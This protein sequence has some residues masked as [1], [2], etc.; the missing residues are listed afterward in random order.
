MIRESISLGIA[1][2][3]GSLHN[4]HVRLHP[5]HLPDALF[6]PGSSFK[7]G[8][9]I[10]G[11]RRNQIGECDVIFAN[12]MDFRD[13]TEPYGKLPSNLVTPGGSE[14][15]CTAICLTPGVATS[16][17]P[18]KSIKTSPAAGWTRTESDS[19]PA[20]QPYA[21]QSLRH[22]GRN[23]GRRIENG[24]WRDKNGYAFEDRQFGLDNMFSCVKLGNTFEEACKLARA[25]FDRQLMEA[26]LDPWTA[27][28]N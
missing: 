13:T 12:T 26:G 19:S 22:R 16:D 17:I 3:I 20:P 23:T 9:R 8:V 28:E 4:S 27:E 10:A 7:E 18:A 2:D 14:R 15:N 6:D 11:E 21:P 5:I 1:L 24:I 25:D